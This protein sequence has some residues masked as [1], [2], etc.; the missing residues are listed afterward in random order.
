MPPQLIRRTVE[1]AAL[2]CVAAFALNA[3]QPAAGL[4][5][6][7]GPGTIVGIVVDTTGRPVDSAYVYIQFPKREARTGRDGRFRFNDLPSTL[8]F[9]LGVRKV[10]FEPQVLV[11]RL[12]KTGGSIRIAMKRLPNFLP[13]V[14][15]EA[16]QP[17]LSGLVT[18]FSGEPVA[19]ARV[20]IVASGNGVMVTGANGRFALDPKP[21]SYM[22]TVAKAK[23]ETKVASVTIPASGGKELKVALL[24]QL[25][26]GYGHRQAAN[27][28]DMRRRLLYKWGPFSRVLTHEDILKMGDV[29]MRQMV[30]MTTAARADEDCEISID[31]GMDRAP[32]WAVD[33]KD[34]ESM[35]VYGSPPK[36][37]GEIQRAGVTSIMG[38]GPIGT[39]NRGR[40]SASSRLDRNKNCPL[41]IAWTRK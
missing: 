18:N 10:G 14:V 26:A 3:Q 41:V 6:K 2:V 30:S 11:S 13:P 4:P 27:M 35:E 21:G 9:D 17:G 36:A 33:V 37:P 19:G 23:F 16:R 5:P 1:A 8:D 25:N 22:V 34:F 39:Q 31:G 12:D 15:T 38:N 24:P 29:D 28:D 40:G 20:E 32:I 7:A